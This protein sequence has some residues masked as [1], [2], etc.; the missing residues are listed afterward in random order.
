[1]PR[2]V[3]PEV[4]GAR[5]VVVSLI[6]HRDYGMA[7]HLSFGGGRTGE[8][9]GRSTV[10]PSVVDPAAKKKKVTASAAWREARE[11]IWAHRRRLTIGL[12]LMLISRAASFVLPASSRWLVDEVAIKGRAELLPPIVFAV[13]AATVL[14]AITSFALSQIL[15]VAAQRAITDM[16]KRVQ[17]QILH[18]PV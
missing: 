2:V 13:G 1:M 3:V 17:A 16:R 5:V 8:R 10:H 14:Q 6:Q 18:L 4:R 12:T 11:L 7:R 9:A 15:G